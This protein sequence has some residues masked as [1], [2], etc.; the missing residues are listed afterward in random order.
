MGRLFEPFFSS[1]VLWLQ[2]R[3]F[4]A[5]SPTVHHTVSVSAP[6]MQMCSASRPCPPPSTSTGRL[7]VEQANKVAVLCA[8]KGDEEDEGDDDDDEE[9]ER[10]KE[11][12][13]SG[14]AAAGNVSSAQSANLFVELEEESNLAKQCQGQ[15]EVH[16]MTIGVCVCFA[17]WNSMVALVFR[18]RGNQSACMFFLC[19]CVCIH[20]CD[21]RRPSVC[22][23][24]ACTVWP[25]DCGTPPFSVPPES[26][27]LPN[28]PV[29]LAN[30]V[31]WA[32]HLEPQ[33]EWEEE[34]L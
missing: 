18:R 14:Y 5:P 33:L 28:L 27:D 4:P 7:T 23:S 30:I 24:F 29:P 31:R 26:G 6:V 20:V 8:K 17:F 1:S 3:I 12:E 2:L 22:V 19:S 21:M 15:S 9:E 16:K 11:N 34:E 32:S 10:E 13:K 25:P